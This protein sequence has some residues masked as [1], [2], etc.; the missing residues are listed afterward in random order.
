V[1]QRGPP[2]AGAPGGAVVAC[3]RNEETIFRDVS[4]DGGAPGWC[5]AAH[6]AQRER[7]ELQCSAWLRPGYTSRGTPALATSP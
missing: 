1:G 5:H 7:K 3:Q 6:G 4:T 2:G